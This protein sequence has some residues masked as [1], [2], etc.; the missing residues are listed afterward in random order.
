MARMVSK[1]M[2]GIPQLY[3]QNGFVLLDTVSHRNTICNDKQVL[4]PHRVKTDFYENTFVNAG[5]R[6][7]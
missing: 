4:K 3:V 2:Y 5:I 6:L 7:D 1:C